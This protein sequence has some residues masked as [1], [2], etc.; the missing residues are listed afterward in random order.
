MGV[1]LGALT[2]STQL[3]RIAEQAALYPGMVFDNLYHKVDV[4][5]LREAYRKTRKDGAP[6]LD[7]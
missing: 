2:I 7:R 3:Q 1:T 5:L 4:G 6:G